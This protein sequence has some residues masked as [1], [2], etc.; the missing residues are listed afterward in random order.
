[1]HYKNCCEDSKY[2]IAEDQFWESATST[3]LMPE[4]DFRHFHMKKTYR[5]DWVNKQTRASCQTGSGP[6]L[7]SHRTNISYSNAHCA[8]C[9]NDFDASADN[10]WPVGYTCND[11]DDDIIYDA[12]I[13]SRDHNTTNVELYFRNYSHSNSVNYSFPVDVFSFLHLHNGTLG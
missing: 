6:P 13:T 2:F 7:T 9:N 1:V 10:L 11:D 5:S 12:W 8:I 3:C 4:N